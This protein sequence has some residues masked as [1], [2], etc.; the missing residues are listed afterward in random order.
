MAEKKQSAFA[1]LEI[2][3]RESDEQHIL[4]TKEILSNWKMNTI[5]QLNAEPSMQI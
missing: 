4:S 3:T 5:Y 2:L 1:L